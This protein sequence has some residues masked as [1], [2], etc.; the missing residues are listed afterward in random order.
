[1]TEKTFEE[2][3]Q[4]S[5][6]EDVWKQS[7]DPKSA[8]NMIQRV[9][10]LKLIHYFLGDQWYERCL[11]R[12]TP[13]FSD[14][15]YL[16]LLRSSSPAK[17]PLNE[18]LWTGQPSDII[19]IINLGLALKV[20]C[21]EYPESGVESRIADL[22]SVDYFKYFFELK[23]GLTYANLGFNVRY[24]DK[25]DTRTPEM[26]VRGI[27]NYQS[28]VECKKRNPDSSSNLKQKANGVLDRI[29][30]ANSQFKSVSGMGITWVEVD[31]GLKKNGPELT[32]YL[33]YVLAELHFLTNTQCVLICSE[34]V[35]SDDDLVLYS[36]SVTG[37]PNPSVQP[38]VPR[39]L[40]C[41]PERLGRGTIRSIVDY[42]GAEHPNIDVSLWYLT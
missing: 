19:N 10:A 4:K 8:F 15:R 42:P 41:N 29:R 23:V 18:L 11:A 39:E 25:R 14:P 5:T 26:L 21:I 22:R 13:D 9:A 32:T 28:Y 36:T 24:L 40:W 27:K 1:M 30:D 31:S 33:E 17:H 35:R 16:R 38:T 6:L 7:A 37:V 3:V 12:S 34:N 20:L 2:I